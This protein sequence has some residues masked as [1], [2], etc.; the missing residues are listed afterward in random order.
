MATKI[1]SNKA[2]CTNCES[3]IESFHR[4]DFVTCKCGKISVDGGKDYL[5]RVGESKYFIDFSE[6]E[7]I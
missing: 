3:I 5:R 7:E 4:H 1:I 6:V 2:M